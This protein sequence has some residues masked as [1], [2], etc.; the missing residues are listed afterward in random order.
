VTSN[1]SFIFLFCFFFSLIFNFQELDITFIHDM[2]K[3]IYPKILIIFFNTLT[4]VKLLTQHYV[5]TYHYQFI[6][7]TNVKIFVS[8][9]SHIIL[10][11]DKFK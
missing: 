6:I 8:E 5:F 9:L 10:L 1:G 3:A 4:N 11:F 7:L 2:N